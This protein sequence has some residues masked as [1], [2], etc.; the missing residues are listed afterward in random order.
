MRAE[1]QA[2]PSPHSLPATTRRGWREAATSPRRLRNVVY[3]A[4]AAPTLKPAV[5]LNRW[6]LRPASPSRRAEAPGASESASVVQYHPLIAIAPLLVRPGMPCAMPG[7]ERPGLVQLVAPASGAF[8]GALEPIGRVQCHVLA[9]LERVSASASRIAW[10]GDAG[11]VD[12]V[13]WM[14]SRRGAPA[15]RL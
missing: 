11:E 15:R 3:H 1:L 6:E 12:Q 4:V 9:N 14:N 13:A 2:G 7:P 5:R 8:L 10:R